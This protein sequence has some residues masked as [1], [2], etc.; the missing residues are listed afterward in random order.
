MSSRPVEGHIAVE[1]CGV[2]YGACSTVPLQT[3]CNADGHYRA[4]RALVLQGGL[5]YS[6]DPYTLST[7]GPEMMDG[8]LKPGLPLSLYLGD[9]PV[10][11]CGS[12][13]TQP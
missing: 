4:G 2:A 3:R 1:R 11:G 10:G 8:A 5:P 6:L 12:A 13:S 7:L 9:K